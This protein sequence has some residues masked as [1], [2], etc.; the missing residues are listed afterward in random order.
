M[1][2]KISLPHHK[3]AEA[4]TYIKAHSEGEVK[5][6]PCADF[7]TGCYYGEGQHKA[8]SLVFL[9]RVDTPRESL[10]GGPI[11]LNKGESIFG[12]FPRRIN[13]GVT[14]RVTDDGAN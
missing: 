7:G 10:A 8:H 4:R 14:I 5:T 12:H 9:N 1:S 2:D 3:R 11:I 13:E 6:L